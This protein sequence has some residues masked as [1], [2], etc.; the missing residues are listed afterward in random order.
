MEQKEI[1]IYLKTIDRRNKIRWMSVIIYLTAVLIVTLFLVLFSDSLERYE[2]LYALTVVGGSALLIVLLISPYFNKITPPKRPDGQIISQTE[3][4]TTDDYNKVINYNMKL[5]LAYYLAVPIV[6][7]EFGL[8]AWAYQQ[9][10]Y[11]SSII[12]AGVGTL[13]ILII[14]VFDT[15]SLLADKDKIIIRLGPLKDVIN[16]SDV[17]TIRPVSI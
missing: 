7:L 12:Y 4:K 11:L 17:E 13:L 10:D 8:T 2:Y 1:D 6:I 16:M 15:V 14:Y 3:M 9:E 5:W